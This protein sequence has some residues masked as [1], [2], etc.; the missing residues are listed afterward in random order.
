MPTV[1]TET[2]AS[3][4]D[5]P[6]GAERIQTSHRILSM[7]S[8]G[9]TLTSRFLSLVRRRLGIRST[10]EALQVLLDEGIA[11]DAEYAIIS[12]VFRLGDHRA[13]GLMT[14]M[15]QL[16]W[17]DV[18][19]PGDEMKR[20]IAQSPHSRFPVCEGSI[21][22]ILGIVQVKDLLVQ[23]FGGEPFSLKGLL[24]LPLFLYEGTPA[25]NVLNLFKT[26]GVHFAVVLDEYGAVRGLL[27]LTDILAAIV[28]DLPAGE[29]L[30]QPSAV[31]RDDGSWLLDGAM[32]IDDFKGLLGITDLPEGDYQTLAGWVIE[33]LGRIPQ[34]A[35][36]FEWGG[37]RYEVVDMDGH[38]VDKVVASPID[39]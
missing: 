29:G 22:N 35:D 17:L 4:R 25:L 15:K 23:G 33:R 21:D 6:T 28:G 18:A 34:A 38:R 13:G 24:K 31:H 20:K 39:G 11:G 9:P 27:T 36:S 37:W 10:A 12:R 8:N 1:R 16:V 30:E 19:E 3:E 7:A 26:S 14:P 32:A 2:L 5:D